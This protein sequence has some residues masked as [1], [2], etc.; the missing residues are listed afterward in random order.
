MNILGFCLIVC[1]AVTFACRGASSALSNEAYRL[2]LTEDGGAAVTQNGDTLKSA[3][4]FIVL[5]AAPDPKV[6]LRWAEIPNERVK[7]SGVERFQ[8]RME[9]LT[10]SGDRR[11]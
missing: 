11:E 6:Q 1:L 7:S 10:P 9:T 8:F 3:T 4:Q 5:T 2:S